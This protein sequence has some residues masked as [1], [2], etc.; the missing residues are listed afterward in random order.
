MCQDRRAL[1]PRAIVF[2][3]EETAQDGAEAQHLE[4]VSVHDARPHLAGLAEAD[5]R[6]VDGGELAYG[7]EC[8]DPLA[9]ILDFGDGER[10]VLGADAA[11]TLPD[12]QDAVFAAVDERAEEHGA[13]ETENSRVRANAERKGGD[14][15]SRQRL[16]AGERTNGIP[17][18]VEHAALSGGPI[19]QDLTA[20]PQALSADA[21]RRSADERA[22]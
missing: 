7:R 10:R 19:I 15:R 8:R 5:G 3:A 17:Q 1:C 22:I 16:G 2:S 12:V 21:C 4:V 9:E 14:D 11:G 20:Q 18:V 6:K 13:D